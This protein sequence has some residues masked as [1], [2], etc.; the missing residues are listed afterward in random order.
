MVIHRFISKA[1]LEFS[2]FECSPNI[3]PIGHGLRERLLFG[4]QETYFGLEFI[5]HV[6]ELADLRQ[7]RRGYWLIQFGKD[8]RVLQFQDV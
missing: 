8:L 4:F 1:V 7:C 5:I 2:A 3:K 6:Q